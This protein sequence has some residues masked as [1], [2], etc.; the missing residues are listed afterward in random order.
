MRLK[1]YGEYINFQRD[2]TSSLPMLFL[3]NDNLY[4]D[5]G[6]QRD[7]CCLHHGRRLGVKSSDHF[8]IVSSA[9]FF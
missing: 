4:F 7:I 6:Q 3:G 9:K 8:H 2:Y 5:T 1:R